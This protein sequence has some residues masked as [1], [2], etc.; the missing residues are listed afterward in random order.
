MRKEEIIKA[1]REDL[2]RS[3]KEKLSAPLLKR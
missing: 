3:E 1:N 2:E